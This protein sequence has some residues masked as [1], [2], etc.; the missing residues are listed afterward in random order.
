VTIVGE[1]NVGKSTLL[2]RL[3]KEE[4]AIVSEIH[5]TT[6]DAIED[7]VV[8][9]GLMFRFIDTA[10]IRETHD[11]IEQLG[12]ERTFR[13]IEQ[14]SIVLW[15]VDLTSDTKEIGYLAEE[16][17]VR[18]EGK[19][20]LLI[21]NKADRMTADELS[22][23]IAFYDNFCIDRMVMSAKSDADII[24]LEC[25]L[26]EAANIQQIDENDVIVTNMRHYEALTLAQAAI[27]Q[28]ISGLDSGIS[29]DFLSQDIR[30]C[31]YHLG[32]I[33][34]QQISTEEVLGNIFSKF[35]IGK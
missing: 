26:L 9:S 14:A 4:R 18:A 13:K 31:L 22:R 11:A 25:A 2:N 15:M 17:A 19:K 12:I 24:A 6:R 3:L 28:V 34:G 20:L 33:T 10:G 1:T 35:C 8:I 5:G 21:L 32:E 7:T 27:R 16:I 23:K 30:E 29:G